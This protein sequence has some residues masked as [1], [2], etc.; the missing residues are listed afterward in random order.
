MG[1]IWPVLS[2]EGCVQNV[3]GWASLPETDSGGIWW[4]QESAFNQLPEL[5]LPIRLRNPA[6]D[7]T[8]SEPPSR[9]QFHPLQPWLCPLRHSLHP[10]HQAATGT[11][12][13]LTSE[14]HTPGCPSEGTA[15][16][17]HLRDAVQALHLHVHAHRDSRACRRAKAAGEGTFLS[18]TGSA[19]PAPV[20]GTAWLRHG[21]AVIQILW[22]FSCHFLT[23]WVP[24]FVPEGGDCVCLCVFPGPT[25]MFSPC[26]LDGSTSWITT[27]YVPGLSL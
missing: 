19:A 2:R 23:W 7:F 16:H 14:P 3:R 1:F 17:V 9:S 27:F 26:L 24:S 20:L 11:H 8:A 6:V 18:T 12:R 21:E 13:P 4:A 15:Y 5:L 22:G 10:C 25:W